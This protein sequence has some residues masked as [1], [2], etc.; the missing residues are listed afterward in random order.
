[1]YNSHI[2]NVNCKL[3]FHCDCQYN[4]NGEFKSSHNTQGQNT[5]VIVYSLGDPRILSF[6]KRWLNDNYSSHRKWIVGKE[7]V[8]QYEL[9]DN[10]IFV[11]H[12]MDEKTH[13]RSVDKEPSQY[14]HGNVEVQKGKLSLALIY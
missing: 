11:L 6:R 12:P 3:A 14:Q 7:T 2:E 5:P 4:Y 13:H 9:K 10:S 1:M 8:S